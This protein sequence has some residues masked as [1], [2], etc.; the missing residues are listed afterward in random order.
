MIRRA[1]VLLTV[2]AMLACPFGASVLAGQANEP[3]GEMMGVEKTD[4]AAMFVDIVASRPVGAASLATG[5]LT[6]VVSLPFSLL[7]GN[8]P[9]A[10]DQ[11]M[12]SPAKYTFLRPL[13]DF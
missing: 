1:I 9:E 5:T 12:I 8:T 2:F 6:F 10:F 3:G 7:G 11:L 4:P 13:G